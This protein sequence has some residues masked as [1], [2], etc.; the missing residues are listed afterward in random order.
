MSLLKNNR[1]SITIWTVLLFIL[2]GLPMIQ[3]LIGM[4]LLVLNKHHVNNALEAS[5]TAMSSN[6]VQIYSEEEGEVFEEF[7]AE[8]ARDEAYYIFENN[9]KINGLKNTIKPKE[10]TFDTE[11]IY[12]DDGRKKCKGS[13][14]A[15]ITLFR[16]IP[17]IP[18]T[19]DIK[20]TV[21][22]NTR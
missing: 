16:V 5:I 3:L 1:G 17:V 19:V 20:S 11:F 21:I 14:I 22:V 2:I 18:E 7:D 9:L 4:S 13:I 10:D 8:K 15:S 6:T 12:D